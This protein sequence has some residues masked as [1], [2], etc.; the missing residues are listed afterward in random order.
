MRSHRGLHDEDE[1]ASRVD[2]TPAVEMRRRRRAAGGGAVWE[3][4]V[5]QRLRVH[6]LFATDCCR[7]L[8]CAYARWRCANPRATDARR[9]A[10]KQA[11][12][13]RA[14]TIARRSE[15]P[16][17][18]RRQ[19]SKG[20]LQCTYIRAARQQVAQHVRISASSSRL[21]VARRCSGVSFGN[22]LVA[23]NSRYQSNLALQ[24]HTYFRIVVHQS[25]NTHTALHRSRLASPVVC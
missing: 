4:G 15:A 7:T 17:P 20:I 24:L 23:A 21:H 25:L 6:I 11:H 3:K 12:A 10:S 8:V 5:L 14:S 22:P 1:H 9:R 16:P 13:I 19:Q 2:A 18:H